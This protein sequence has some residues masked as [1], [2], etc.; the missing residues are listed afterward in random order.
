MSQVMTLEEVATSLRLDEKQALMLIK[1]GKLPAMEVDG[2][3]RIHICDLE[4]C[5]RARGMTPV[6]RR[7][8]GRWVS[9][10]AALAVLGFGAL[11]PLKAFE[12]GPDESARQTNGVARVLPFEGEYQRDDMPFEGTA[13]MS[14][15]VYGQSTGGQPLWTSS[16]RSVAIEQG[17]FAVVL[18]DVNDVTALPDTLFAQGGLYLELTIEGNVLTPRQRLAP[19]AQSLHSA[20][21]VQADRASQSSGASGALR[22][23]LD[24]LSS[25]TGT[26]QDSQL[27]NVA[28]G[29]GE[30]SLLGLFAGATSTPTSGSISAP[31][32][33]QGAVAARKL[34]ETDFGAG[35][36]MCTAH[37]I[38]L[39]H[40]AGLVGPGTAAPLAMWV[41]GGSSVRYPV[42]G[43]TGVNS[44]CNGYSNGNASDPGAGA[45]QLL[46][47]AYINVLGGVFDNRPCDQPAQIACCK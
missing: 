26:L 24:T 42:V 5:V 20:R 39:S 32:N 10:G 34:C 23:E 1:Q 30:I 25:D 21:A 47:T 45:S 44:D 46:G 31:G 33:L 6:G 29:G 11:L 40:Q 16:N 9:T 43:G 36:H 3:W 35:A 12:L 27:R 14:F 38:T 8:V 4:A 13:P 18:G 37:E 28:I 22:T 7:R 17:R 19:A 2:Q 15:S 41:H